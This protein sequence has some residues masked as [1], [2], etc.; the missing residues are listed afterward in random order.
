MT[1]GREARNVPN[2]IFAFGIVIGIHFAAIHQLTAASTEV[3]V[4]TETLH[5][6][7]KAAE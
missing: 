1:K 6:H 7:N 5:D 2:C 3:A 4:L